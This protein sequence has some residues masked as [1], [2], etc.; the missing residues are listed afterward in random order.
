MMKIEE[1]K[2][3]K[4]EEIANSW[5]YDGEYA[6]YDMAADPEDYEEIMCPNL[7]GNRYF[8]VFDNDALIGFSCVEQEESFIE[9]GLGLRPDLMGH[10]KGRAFLEEILCYVKKRYLFESIHLDVASFNQRAIKV[11]ER[12]GFVKTGNVLVATNGGQYDFTQME[13]KSI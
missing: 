9:L 1:M 10:G 11:Y 13:L 6:F 5:K 12:A 2:Q 3:P 7:R 8:S 4:A